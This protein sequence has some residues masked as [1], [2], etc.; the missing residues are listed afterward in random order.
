VQREPWDPNKK[1]ALNPEKGSPVAEPFQGF[2]VFFYAHPGLSLR[3]N[4]G[5]GLANAYGVYELNCV[6][7]RL[8]RF[9][10]A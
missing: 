3:S 5:L 1:E 4:P 8:R 7:E 2:V 9:P 10:C 6:S